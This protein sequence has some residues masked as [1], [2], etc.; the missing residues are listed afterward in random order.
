MIRYLFLLSFPHCF[1]QNISQIE[2]LR[3]RLFN[4]EQWQNYFR[5]PL[6]QLWLNL[7]GS[8]MTWKSGY[9]SGLN[10]FGSTAIF[11]SIRG[12][13]G[14]FPDPNPE[15]S[16]IYGQEGRIIWEVLYLLHTVY[17]LRCEIKEEQGL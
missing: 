10:N 5:L 14:S 3:K 6:A 8:N 4:G 13:G 9:G 7:D 16:G 17:N 15:L 1:E 12:G 2:K 11:F